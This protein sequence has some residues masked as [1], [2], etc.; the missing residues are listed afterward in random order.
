MQLTLDYPKEKEAA[1]LKETATV[2]T[3]DK[4]SIMS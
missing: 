2:V 3:A 1:P 4:N